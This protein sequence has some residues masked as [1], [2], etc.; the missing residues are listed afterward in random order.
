MAP[1]KENWKVAAE[2][3]QFM[4]MLPNR[5]QNRG[6][7]GV[8]IKNK[9]LEDVVQPSEGK[10]QEWT[11]QNSP[12]ISYKD[13]ITMQDAENTS[14][15][16]ICYLYNISGY[17]DCNTRC[18]WSQTNQNTFLHDFTHHLGILSGDKNKATCHVKLLDG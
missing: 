4:R 18:K 9:T 17:R 16:I 10:M 5:W 11:G 2:A 3:G 15:Y 6:G 14:L 1:F 12:R 7:G 8:P 13:P